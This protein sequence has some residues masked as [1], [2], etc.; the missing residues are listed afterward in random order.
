MAAD[1]LDRF[2]PATAR[3]V[4]GVVQRAHARP[5]GRLGRRSA[6]AHH[7]LVV[8]PTGSGKTLS[9][10]LWALDR[11]ASD[12]AARGAA[13]ALPGPLRLADEGPRRRRRAQPALAR[14]SASATPPPG[15][16]CRRPTSPSR[17][18]R[19]TP[20]PPTA[21]PSPARP[22]T[23]SSRRPS[24]CSSCSPPS[25]REALAGV[26]T[27]IL[28]EVHAVAGTKRGAHLA[29]SASSASTRC[30][31]AP[32]QRVGLS[33]TVR[34]VE[35]VAR[36]LA[37]G[38]PVEV[39]QPPSTKEWDL[40]VVVPLRRHVR[41]RRA[42]RRPQRAGGR[43]SSGGPRSGRT[44]RS[45]SSTSSPTHRSTLVFA[46]SRRLAERLTARLN[47]IWE[48]RLAVAAAER[49][50]TRRRRQAAVPRGRSGSPAR[51]P[52]EVMAQAG[53]QPRRRARARPG[54]PRLGE[55]GAAGRDRGGP[56]GRPAARRSSRRAASSSAST[57]APSTSSSRSSRRR[58]VAS[59]LQRVG[60]AG[61]QVG[62]V[63]P[64]ACCSRSSAATSCRPPSS[65]SGCAPGRSSRCA[66][67]PTPL[68]VLAQQVVAMC[69]LDDWTVDD[70]EALVRRAAPFATLPALGARVGARHARRA[71][72]Q[73]RVRRA[74]AAASSGTA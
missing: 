10:F 46:N 41:A 66:C 64:R 48:E 11:L 15:S 73:R 37:G 58:S 5:G 29:L 38:R 24:R 1:V 19:A 22:P 33:A 59:G 39:V 51:T 43:A 2:S 42:H 14:S 60:R 13:A 3:V 40:E 8:A 57:W 49:G 44:S 47:E 18:A 27:V 56:Q 30:S 63:S 17:S 12:A 4:P 35:E 72:P 71:L 25:A 36:Y 61:H 70:V 69:A 20:R 74:A 45:A 67:P 50:R 54:P 6:R 16:G 31:R 55:Q 52:A 62:A 21:G 26:E 32:A 53:R 65:S 9:A 34:P 28:D 23:S 7:A 68:D